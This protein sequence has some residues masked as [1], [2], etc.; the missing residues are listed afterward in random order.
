MPRV[1]GRSQEGGR[2]LM[3]E[4]P[5]YCPLVARAP[6]PAPPSRPIM[7]AHL[8]VERAFFIDNL[9]IRIHLTIEIISVDRPCAIGV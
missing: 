8:A 9:L 4:V 2:F 7:V 1:Q 6:P 3:S 5:L